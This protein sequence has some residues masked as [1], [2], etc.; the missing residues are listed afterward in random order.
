MKTPKHFWT[1]TK[2]SLL[3]C[4]AV[5][6]FITGPD[7]INSGGDPP[8]FW[9]AIIPVAF[10]SIFL[11]PFLRAFKSTEQYVTESPWP[12]F[13]FSIFTN[14]FPFWHLCLWGSFTGA[15]PQ[16]Y[17]I[18][19]SYN[20]DQMI[21]ALMEWSFF[22]GTLVG[23]ILTKRGIRKEMSNKGMNGTR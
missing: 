23:I 14:P 1:F 16:T 6:S 18:L 10:F 4:S 22:I 13:P 15:I 11:P 2:A 21:M 9:L 19:K 7:P 12:D 8:P 5:V 17:H 20:H 3:A